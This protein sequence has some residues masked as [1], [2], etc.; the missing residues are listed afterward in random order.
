MSFNSRSEFRLLATPSGSF[1]EPT[2]APFG[3]SVGVSNDV[4][5]F[6]L[7]SSYYRITD[8]LRQHY[9]L[10]LTSV[11]HIL[12]RT[13]I[14]LTSYDL[15]LYQGQPPEKIG[16]LKLEYDEITKSNGFLDRLRDGS[17]KL[18]SISNQIDS[19]PGTSTRSFVTQGSSSSRL[20]YT[21]SVGTK[22][23]IV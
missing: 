12:K 5:D 23:S 10:P 14:V 2:T 17:E 8:A 4:V 9:T 16:N 20:F 1:N 3:Q 19:T 7:S 15:L 6:Y 11:P 18:D 13:E 21:S 22:E